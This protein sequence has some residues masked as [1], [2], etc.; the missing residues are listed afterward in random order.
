MQCFA[1][2]KNFPSTMRLVDQIN[3]SESQGPTQDQGLGFRGSGLEFVDLRTQII[4]KLLFQKLTFCKTTS[5]TCLPMEQQEPLTCSSLH[6]PSIY[7]QKPYSPKPLYNPSLH[8]MVHDF[9][10]GALWTHNMVEPTFMSIIG[11][12]SGHQPKNKPA[13]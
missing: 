8:F 13:S 1:W 9:F 7:L 2:C 12:Q 3:S 5:P 6:Q 10:F 4:S 11:N